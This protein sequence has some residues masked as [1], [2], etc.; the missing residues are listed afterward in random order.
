MEM[1]NKNS[2]ILKCGREKVAKV[3]S[4]GDRKLESTHWMMLFD[5]ILR[6]SHG[7][8]AKLSDALTGRCPMAFQDDA[9]SLVKS[10][11]F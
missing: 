7:T 9:T 11:C 1:E 10:C 4:E 6:S 5:L 3:E 2:Q 8:L